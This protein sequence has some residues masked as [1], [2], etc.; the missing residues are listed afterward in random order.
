MLQPVQVD[1]AMST[2]VKQQFTLAISGDTSSKQALDTAVERC[3][4]LLKG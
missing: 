1:D 2:I 4:Q 3:N